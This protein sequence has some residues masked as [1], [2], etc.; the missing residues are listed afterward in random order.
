MCK[1]YAGFGDILEIKED[2]NPNIVSL[3]IK[4]DI[5]DYGN[6]K[7]VSFILDKYDAIRISEF[8]LKKFLMII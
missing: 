1:F 8:L 3:V 6:S 2:E 7:E 5:D 4:E